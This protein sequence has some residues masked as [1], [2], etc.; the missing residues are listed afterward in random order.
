MPIDKPEE[1]VERSVAALARI[2]EVHLDILELELSM[3][4]Q[5]VILGP[6]QAGDVMREMDLALYLIRQMEE[7][8]EIVRNLAEKFGI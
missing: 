5:K 4:S 6:G 8:A 3:V 2:Q 7:K 1:F